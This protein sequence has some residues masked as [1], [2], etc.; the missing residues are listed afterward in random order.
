MTD[1]DNILDT[2]HSLVGDTPVSEQLGTALDRMSAKTHDHDQYAL[3]IEVE[4]LK[5]KIDLLYD[6]VGDMPVSEQI[7]AAIN[8]IK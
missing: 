3:R 8:N 6:L 2:L 4:E 5:K 7:N 1:Q